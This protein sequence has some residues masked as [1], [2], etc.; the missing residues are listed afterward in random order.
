MVKTKIICTIGPASEQRA[1]L[2]KMITAG[3]DVA[4]LNCSHGSQPGRL[5]Q[6]VAIRDLNRKRRRHIRIL[7]DLEG[8]RVR[9]GRFAQQGGIQLKKGAK[10]RLARQETASARDVIPFDYEGPLGDIKRGHEIFIDDGNI[11]LVVSGRRGNFLLAEVVIPGLLKQH[12]G[13]N[14]PGAKLS[15]QGLTERDKADILFGLDVGVD[16][17]AQSFVRDRGDIDILRSFIA[18]HSQ[19]TVPLIAKIENRQG[20]NNI[21]EIISAADGVMVARGDMG[22]SI[23]IYEVPMVQKKL[24]KKCRRA[25][26]FAI[27]ATQMLESMTENLRPTR[28]EVTDVANA[29]LD[30]TDY[31][32]LSGETAAGAHPVETVTM[33]NDIIKHT[34]REAARLAGR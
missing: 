30:G 12:K 29:V 10:L 26:K 31:V 21:D 7:L 15:F 5:R 34:E 17:I 14:I 33:M 27:T 3:M 1:T 24:I 32:M 25:K 16:Y 19:G 4:R 23:P 2:R 28:A 11:C 13:I 6:I 22:V 8:H 20:I 9:V 18:E